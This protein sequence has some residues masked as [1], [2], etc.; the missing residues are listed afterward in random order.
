MKV[1]I[2]YRREDSA[3][4]SGRLHDSLQ[5]HFGADNVF[6]DLSDIDSGQNFVDV[7]QGA[8]RSSDV[9][10]AVIGKEWLTCASGGTRRLDM[11]NDFVRTEIGIAL[12]HGIP[13]M[14]VLV[15][16]A[17]MPPASSLPEPLKLLASHDAHDVSDERWTYDVGR[18]I[19]ATEKL[20]GKSPGPRRWPL[21]AAVLVAAAAIGAFFFL[22]TRQPQVVL[23][24]DWSANVAY[25]WGDKYTERFSF[26][27]DGDAVLGT[28]SF[29]GVRR[30]IVDGSLQ[31]E[32]VV[33]Q[34]RTQEVRGDFDNPV[35]V[36][37]R[38]RGTITGDTIAFT[39]QSE[40]GSSSVPVEFT[41]TR[42]TSAR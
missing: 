8:V 21:I 19:D 32:R 28:A 4:H 11:P 27:V 16:G 7:I 13:V 35:S 29:L 14:P 23:T 41:A 2:S 18:L 24:G 6:M 33:F 42:S 22:Q 9:V 30:G 39:M 26:K 38:Y 12:E 1:F 40:G 3:G 17:G 34:T 37:H 5:S 15:R 20:A 31:G 25:D 10:L 36:S